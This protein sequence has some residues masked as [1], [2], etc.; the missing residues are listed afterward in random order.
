M[1]EVVLWSTAGWPRTD[2]EYLQEL[3]GAFNRGG[4][5]PVDHSVPCPATVL[6][7]LP[8]PMAK[9]PMPCPVLPLF[10]GLHRCNPRH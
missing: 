3:E 9:L 8:L 1:H 2:H 5:F 7:M 4:P 6:T 10:R